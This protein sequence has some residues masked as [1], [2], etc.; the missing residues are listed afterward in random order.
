[1]KT[2]ELRERD[3]KAPRFPR[4]GLRVARGTMGCS[5]SWEPG[6]Q[7]GMPTLQGWHAPCLAKHAKAQR[8]ARSRE[9]SVLG[10]LL[11]GCS[12]SWEGVGQ[13]L[14]L[15]GLTRVGSASVSSD[16]EDY[17]S[18]DNTKDPEEGVD[19]VMEGSSVGIGFGRHG[20]K[21]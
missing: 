2:C 21:Y 5:R 11:M 13:A 7:T 4:L 12:P 14:S 15:A 1:M 20:G 3:R 9:L 6:W 18:N 19:A 10:Y 17:R 16:D 8:S